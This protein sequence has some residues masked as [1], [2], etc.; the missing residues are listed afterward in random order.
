MVDCYYNKQFEGFQE[1]IHQSVRTDPTIML[2]GYKK[3][4]R[5]T[6]LS[7]VALCTKGPRVIIIAAVTFR[8]A[9]FIK[10][11]GAFIAFLVVSG[12]DGTAPLCLGSWRRQG[13]ASFMLSYG[14]QQ[15]WRKALS[16]CLTIFQN[17]I[18]LL[19]SFIMRDTFRISHLV[20][21]VPDFSGMIHLNHLVGRL[22]PPRVELSGF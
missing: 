1:V 10:P 12:A 11:G 7:K 22:S 18:G 16:S 4:N 9:S 13:F 15:C 2:L 5:S 19:Q 8:P 17:S 21:L 3:P 14:I 20:N 6:N